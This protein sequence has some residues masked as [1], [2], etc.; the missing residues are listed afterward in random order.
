MSK[1]NGVDV[2]LTGWADSTHIGENLKY[3]GEYGGLNET[4]FSKT[5]SA[6]IRLEAQKQIADNYVLA[7]LRTMGAKQYLDKWTKLVH[8]KGTR[9][10]IH[11]TEVNT[12]TAGGK[13]R[14]VR[15][16]L[17]IQDPQLSPKENPKIPIETGQCFFCRFITWSMGVL[18]ILAWIW[19]RHH[20]EMDKNLPRRQYHINWQIAAT[21]TAL[22]LGILFVWCN[23]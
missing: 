21:I 19:K 6:T 11:Q 13:Y 14:K 23:L 5:S 2:Y 22:L 9:R 10:T 20:K 4:Y 12:E 8:F 3:K 1:S 7:F 17:R 16:E 15:I 18:P